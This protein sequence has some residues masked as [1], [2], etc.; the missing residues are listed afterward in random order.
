[1][2]TRASRLVAV[3]LGLAIATHLRSS[4]AE[5][6]SRAP[7]RRIALLVGSNDGGPGSERLRYAHI[8]AKKLRSVLVELG[9]FR[10]S[11]IE[12]VWEPTE[13]QLADALDRL[14][15]R[16]VE[17]KAVAESTT[18]LVY[19]S[20]HARAGELLLGENRFSLGR[21]RKAIEVSGADVRLGVIDACESGEM[22]RR[23][24]G[25]PA[26]SFLLALDQPESARGVVLMT[27]SSEGEESQE[28]DEVGGS[29]FTHYLTSG[30]R[31]DADASGDSKVTLSEL[32]QYTYNKTVA[33][34]ARSR[35]GVQHPTYSYDLAG[36][37]AQIVL[38]DLSLGR[39]GVVFPEA[40]AGHYLVLD[41]RREMIAIELDKTAGAMRRVALAPGEYVVK[42]RLEAEL[43]TAEFLLGEGE[44]Y[45]VSDTN[46]TQV[47]LL[48]D[49]KKGLAALAELDRPDRARTTL[50]VF[51][52]F[53]SFLSS[54]ARDRL[55]PRAT[56]LGVSFVRDPVLGGR[57]GLELVFGGN[58]S[59]RLELDGVGFDVT[60]FEAQLAAN[61]T[62][63]P[64]GDFW[65][66]EAGPRLVGLY[67][68]RKF[69]SDPDLANLT[70]D[71]FTLSPGAVALA[72]LQLE[73][74]TLEARAG[75]GLLVFS[76]DEN[77]TLLFSEV[78]IG[79]GYRL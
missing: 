17:A 77:R 47:E 34:T 13:A 8:D 3:A 75:L 54:D 33:E 66:L 65:A 39:S 4:S 63:G 25:R 14:Q 31:G 18:A 43:H 69:P 44:E 71:H 19:Y 41:A 42:R 38:S 22:T 45:V 59:G 5:A 78:G 7:V 12:T 46:M 53:Q 61:W 2:S 70:Q 37:N 36:G 56:L 64:R 35:A 24:G 16:V 58:G 62:F 67:L 79:L 76:V 55:F 74:F 6:P 50:G 32:Y 29:F 49:H 26:P 52:V 10:E 23:K 48:E 51:S 11:D 21:L 68:L 57:L 27:S 28:S 73:G 40:L 60:F 9:G 30:L 1:M 72:R 15:R 20:G